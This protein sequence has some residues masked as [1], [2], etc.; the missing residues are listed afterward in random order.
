MSS[1]RIFEGAK[2]RGDDAEEEI[3]NSMIVFLHGCGKT[4][5]T[6]AEWMEHTGHRFPYWRARA[7][8]RTLPAV[9]IGDTRK[10]ARVYV[11]NPSVRKM[12]DESG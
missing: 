6:C 2:L 4:G 5:G 1:T 9:P 10:R 3:E 11:L 7:V 8:W 12:M